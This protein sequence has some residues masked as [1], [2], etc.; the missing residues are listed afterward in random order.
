MHLLEAAPRLGGAIETEKRDG[1]LLEKGPDA[2]ISKKPWALDLARRVGLSP[3]IIGTREENRRSFVLQKG[4]LV[5]VPEG[6]YL[7]SPTQVRPFLESSLFSLPG[8]LRILMEA[9]IPQRAEESDESVGS[10]IRRRFGKEALGRVGQAM[11]AGIYAGDPENLSLLATMPRFRE[12]EKKYGSVTRGL[13]KEM[14]ENKESERAAGPRYGLFV[15]FR[16][17]MGVLVE[18]LS[19][20][21]PEDC[22]KLNFPVKEVSY[23]SS[24]KYWKLLAQNGQRR[25][26]D[27]VCL[28]LP[29]KDAAAQLKNSVEPLSRKLSRIH[30]ESVLTVN[31]GYKREEIPHP[32]D[33][34]GFVVPRIENRATIA[35]TFCDR[36]FEGRAPQGFSLLRAFVGGAFGKKYFD[37]SD[38]EMIK[39]VSMDFKELLGIQG[40]PL[41]TAL[42]RHPESMVQYELGH[43]DLVSEIQKITPQNLGLYLAGSSYE[44]VGIPDCVKDAE[45]TAEKIFKSL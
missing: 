43:L 30:Y 16:E 14:P 38:S 12:L 11:L 9:A 10:F 17:G 41:F 18:A 15:S 45:S 23:D 31:L 44:G 13:L 3:Q 26:F 42:Q 40:K 35:C 20:K 36:K 8:K 29:A 32:L 21:I 39:L 37:K 25:V 5:P 19:K 2:F 34:F 7:I 27:R 1:F 22:V 4:R 28:T 24:T 6:F 33:G